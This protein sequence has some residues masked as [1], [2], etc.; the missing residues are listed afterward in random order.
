[1][2]EAPK[3]VCEKCGLPKD[4]CCCKEVKESKDFT[5]NCG[6]MYEC[7]YAPGLHCNQRPIMCDQGRFDSHCVM[8]VLRQISVGIQGSHDYLKKCGMEHALLW[9]FDHDYIRPKFNNLSV[10]QIVDLI[11]KDEKYT[12]ENIDR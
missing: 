10:S 9:L 1:M 5:T 8:N 4:L 3:A 2:P 11:I 7:Q 12:K 6:K